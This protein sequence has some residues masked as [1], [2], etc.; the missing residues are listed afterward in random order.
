MA[1]GREDERVSVV[2]GAVLI[3]AVLRVLAVLLQL[4]RTCGSCNRILPNPILIFHPPE[5]A[6]TGNAASSFVKPIAPNTLSTLRSTAV[7]SAVS[8]S[9]CNEAM[10]SS[11]DCIRSASSPTSARSFSHCAYSASNAITL[12]KVERNSSFNVRSSRSSS[13]NS[14]RK[15][16]T[17]MSGE[18]LINSPSSNSSSSASC[19]QKGGEEERREKR[20][21]MSAKMLCV[22]V[23]LCCVCCVR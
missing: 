2:V 18:D 1:V 7:A 11:R 5:K 10:R 8:S 17:V 4:L 9:V 21:Q 23:C 13:R 19:E 22:C 14:W 6:D 20:C 15:K 3:G 16:E 12:S